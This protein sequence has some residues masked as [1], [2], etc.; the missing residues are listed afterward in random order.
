M[1]FAEILS[2]G[3][4]SARKNLLISLANTISCCETVECQRWIFIKIL[5]YGRKL[6]IKD[7]FCIF[8]NNYRTIFAP[9]HRILLVRPPT[10][11]LI[12]ILPSLI[13]KTTTLTSTFPQVSQTDVVFLSPRSFGNLNI[14]LGLLPMPKTPVCLAFLTS[15]N[16]A[17]CS[18]RGKTNKIK[19]R[20]SRSPRHNFNLAEFNTATPIK[21][22]R[23]L[24][25]KFEFT[26]P[27]AG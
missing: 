19:N 2:R 15:L 1:G 4:D 23:R 11:N 14:C 5:I 7:A 25:E 26:S 27:L 9:L 24:S 20:P 18:P 22:S 8:T 6:S 17:Q 13:R 16:D 21:A 3:E 12:I 10:T